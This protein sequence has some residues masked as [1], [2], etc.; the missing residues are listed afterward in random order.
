MPKKKYELT[1]EGIGEKFNTKGKRKKRI[2]DLQG[3][4]KSNYGRKK[5]PKIRILSQQKELGILNASNKLHEEDV[6]NMKSSCQIKVDGQ[7]ISNIILSNHTK[8]ELGIPIG[9]NRMDGFVFSY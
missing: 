5:Q 7:V 3:M 2:A 1:T 4:I 8:K 9:S 6:P